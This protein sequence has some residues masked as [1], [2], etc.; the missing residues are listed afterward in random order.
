MRT[1][2]TV[3]RSGQQISRTQYKPIRSTIGQ[4]AAPLEFRNAHI[5]TPP[6]PERVC[7]CRVH[8]FAFAISPAVA[9]LFRACVG[10]GEI[11]ETK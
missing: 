2:R 10:C 8:G 9:R 11:K 7:V 3:E 5:S 6:L 1:R 4:E